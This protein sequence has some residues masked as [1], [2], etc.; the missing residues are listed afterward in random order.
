MHFGKERGDG[1]KGHFKVRLLTLI[2]RSLPLF[3][4]LF[5]SILLSSL[6]YSGKKHEEQLLRRA[7]LTSLETSKVRLSE[8]IRTR[9]FAMKSL[10]EHL[11]SH[12]RAGE[13]DRDLFY[14]VTAPVYKSFGGFRAI[15][16]IDRR[17]V[18]TWVYPLQSNRGA[19][20]KEIGKHPRKSVVKTFDQVRSSGTYSI[21][22][23]VDLFQGGPGVA[24]YF[25][26]KNRDGSVEGY[27]NGVLRIIPLIETALAGKVEGN[28]RISQG[29]KPLVSTGEPEGDVLETELSLKNLK[30]LIQVWPDDELV[31]AYLGT[32]SIWVLFI[33]LLVSIVLSYAVFQLQRRYV[34]LKR[35]DKELAESEIKFRSLVEHSLVGIYIIQDGLFRYV[36]PRFCDIFGY[37]SVEIMDEKGPRDLAYPEDWPM[38]EKNLNLRLEGE[39]ESLDYTFRSVRA[40]GRV[41]HVEVYGVRLIYGGRPA[42]IGMLLD[43][44]DRL[45]LE[46]QLRQS[47]RLE[48]LG[49]FAG[50]VA[51]DFNNILTAITGYASLLGMKLKD[52]DLK[53]KI[54]QI[55]RASDRAAT[56]THGLLAF[57]RKQILEPRSLFLRS[58]VGDFEKILRRLIPETIELRTD[59]GET[60]PV[61]ADKGQVEQV[62]MNLITNARD[63]MPE[64]GE[65]I[66]E[67]FDSVFDE[68]YLSA[69]PWIKRKGRFTCLSISDTGEGMEDEVKSRVFEPFFTTKEV[70]KGTGLG[71]PTVY[72]IVKQHGGFIHLY[73]EKG[74]GT[75]FKIYLPVTE[76]EPCETERETVSVLSDGTERIL[77]AEDD[78]IVRSM[79]CEV[80]KERGYEVTS[81]K[82]GA[83]AVEIIRE[84]KDQLDLLVLDVVMPL[85]GGRD[86]LE[87]V[88]GLGYSGG[89]LFISG[90]TVNA[91]HK[92]FFLEEGLNFLTK[93]FDLQEFLRKVRYVLDSGSDE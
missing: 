2:K 48:S 76:A 51:H 70:G 34:D 88:R 37:S 93:P 41:I 59:L 11:Q 13:F 31:A 30:L 12:L 18:I 57:S 65:I 16:W 74:R 15:N 46:E 73:S 28:Y 63:A 84:R 92:D 67:T 21:T 14:M 71:L 89:V 75:T 86:V 6:W 56:L 50:G 80:L 53:D 60:M 79:A 8:A 3:V 69:H 5:T 26:V 36:N 64:G 58:V 10:T 68:E 72:G 17:G 91:I 25:P 38:V 78:E 55:L 85:K 19:V 22:P 40:D 4:L 61:M 44:T 77:V 20:G 62:I 24:T 42:V 39:A 43:I 82:D 32:H 33:L 7:L 1:L 47:Q 45:N 83:E 90:Y 35:K 49:L 9:I 66:I 54:D 23:V 27:V 87:E 52:R 29:G 81:V